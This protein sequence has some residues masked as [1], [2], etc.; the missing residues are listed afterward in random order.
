MQPYIPSSTG[1]LSHRR[2]IVDP[3][4]QGEKVVKA[5]H[6]QWLNAWRK[7]GLLALFHEVSERKTGGR[8]LEYWLYEQGGATGIVR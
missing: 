3:W 1:R 6:R 4:G 2:H 8:R 7:V 5:K